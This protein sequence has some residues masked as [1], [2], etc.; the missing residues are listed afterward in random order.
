MRV[1]I[2]ELKA[3][4]SAYLKQVRESGEPIEVCVREDPVAYLVPVGAERDSEKLH[5]KEELQQRLGACGLK[6]TA[7][8]TGTK[9]G[10]LRPCPARDGRVDVSSV[11]QMREGRDW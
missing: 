8:P 4:L 2:G 10:K 6:L 9:P 11:K 1:R 7:G 5:A 3:K